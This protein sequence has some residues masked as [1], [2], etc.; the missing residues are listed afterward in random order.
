MSGLNISTG[1]CPVKDRIMTYESCFTTDAIVWREVRKS[2]V[3]CRRLKTQKHS[4]NID[5]SCSSLFL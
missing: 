5:L 3:S 4:V 1:Q 2:F